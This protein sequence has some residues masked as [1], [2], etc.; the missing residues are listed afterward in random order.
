MDYL[1]C[2]I[3]ASLVAEKKVNG[4][5][6]SEANV[7]TA[8]Q[9]IGTKDEENGLKKL[10]GIIGGIFLGTG[11]SSLISI[12]QAGK[13]DRTGII[14]MAV[15]GI[16]GAFLVAT[17]LPGGILPERRK[18]RASAQNQPAR[19]RRRTVPKTPNSQE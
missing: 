14:L 1:S 19:V 17:D 11:I 7:H 10:A 6:V 9:I 12:L 15:C 2:L 16:L 4:D 8:S 18:R 3:D 5:Q 13:F